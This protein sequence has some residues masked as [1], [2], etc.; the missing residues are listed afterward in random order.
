EEIIRITKV[1]CSLGIGLYDMVVLDRKMSK[2]NP[3]YLHKGLKIYEK[4]RICILSYLQK[5]N[6]D[7]NRNIFKRLKVNWY[8]TPC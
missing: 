8:T 3:I 5:K 7:F 2:M 1:L 6:R 4:V